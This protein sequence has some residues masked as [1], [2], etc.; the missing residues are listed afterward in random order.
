MTEM[1]RFVYKRAAP[2]LK[3]LSATSDLAWQRLVIT[4]GGE[5]EQIGQPLSPKTV[6]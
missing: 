6:S 2:V 4:E 5:K 3:A 1:S